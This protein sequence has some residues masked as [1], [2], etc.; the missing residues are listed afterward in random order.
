MLSFKHSLSGQPECSLRS[1][2]ATQHNSTGQNEQ[3]KT[4]CNG[5]F[6][7]A[8]YLFDSKTGLRLSLSTLPNGTNDILS[9][10]IHSVH[11]S[12][13]NFNVYFQWCLK[14]QETH[15]SLISPQLDLSFSEAVLKP[16]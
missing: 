15:S 3:G 2:E 10:F 14:T 12:N 4:T 9:G 11:S 8:G 7:I 16:I 6:V 1:A 5:Y 13:L